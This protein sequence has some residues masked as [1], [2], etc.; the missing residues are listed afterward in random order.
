LIL[1]LEAYCSHGGKGHFLLLE[2]AKYSGRVASA[3]RNSPERQILCLRNASSTHRLGAAVAHEIFPQVF[4]KPA[5]YPEVVRVALATPLSKLHAAALICGVLSAALGIFVLIGWSFDIEPLMSVLPGHIRMKPNAAVLF[6]SA[7]IA[8]ALSLRNSRRSRRL[9]RVLAIVVIF[10]SL[11]TLVEYG[12]VVDFHIDEVLFTD[13]VQRTFPGRMAL[14]TCV[15]FCLIGV[16][17]LC[18]N[19]S[20]R[21]R[22]MALG[23]ALFVMADSYAAIVAS[24]YGVRILYGAIDY[25]SMALHT[26]AGFLTIGAGI[27]LAQPESTLLGVL[28]AP[29]NGGR[30]ARRILPFVLLLPVALGW[31]Y[32]RPSVDFGQPHFGMALM[33]VTLSCS[34]SIALWVL[35]AF[36]N[37][38]ERE[39]AE[40][41]REREESAMAIRQSERELRLVTDHLPTLL[42]YID[43]DGR[44]LRVNRTYELWTGLPANAIVGKTIREL[45]GDDYWA[46]TSFALDSVLRG[47]TITFETTYPRLDGE[48]V[49]EITYAPNTDET[50]SVRGIACMVADVDER[51]KAQQVMRESETLHSANKALHELATTDK[52]TGMKN[53][54]AFDERLSTEFAASKEGDEELSVLL[55]DVDNFKSRNDTW[56]HAAGDEVLRKLG[57]VLSAAVRKPDLAAR[58]GGEEFAVLLPVSG[59]TAATIVANR[60]VKL[61]AEKNWDEEQLTVSIGISTQTKAMRHEDELVSAADAALYEAKRTGKN[62][63]CY[64]EP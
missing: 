17:L 33:A 46:R 15:N 2:M 56:G 9:A 11:L 36:L 55:I 57:S 64:W 41:S 47:E 48:R 31:I 13:H 21:I 16:S 7:G 4:S 10:F 29:Q 32:L 12:A 30:M 44:F 3:K 63:I 27:V 23:L 25:K 6:F 40:F 54:R 60:I 51:R 52:L 22:W 42:S 26:G 43:P 50:G 1:A 20:G 37:R 58:Y 38:A 45:M 19:A 53:R 14:I 24:V 35:A 39:Q 18:L 62:R 59:R 34:G 5:K 61:V 49:V 8:L 28:C